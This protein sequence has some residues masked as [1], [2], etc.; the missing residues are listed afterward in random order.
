MPPPSSPSL[1]LPVRTRRA[2]VGVSS[3]EPSEPAVLAEEAVGIGE[4][5]PSLPDINCPERWSPSTWD[6]SELDSTSV[7][8]ST[9]RAKLGVSEYR[10]TDFS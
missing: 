2:L 8:E 9:I 6:G 4:V 7:T 10:K 5:R 1:H 3:V